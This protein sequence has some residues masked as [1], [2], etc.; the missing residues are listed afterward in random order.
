MNDS[1]TRNV[2]AHETAAEN[3]ARVFARHGDVESKVKASAALL[4]YFSENLVPSRVRLDVP[5]EVASRFE[6][7]CLW[8]RKTLPIL[9]PE[10]KTQAEK[11]LDGANLEETM[12]ALNT[13]RDEYRRQLMYRHRTIFVRAIMSFIPGASVDDLDSKSLEFLNVQ[14][15]QN[16][17]VVLGRLSGM[18]DY[19]ASDLEEVE[20]ID[21]MKYLSLIHI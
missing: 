12:V 4:K 9:A 14:N 15:L 6:P 1:P 10:V 5:D 16:V 20:H 3:M 13:L 2:S 19:A 11:L 7:L 18:L 17:K 21:D 8:V